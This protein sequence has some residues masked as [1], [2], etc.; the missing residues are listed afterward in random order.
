MRNKFNDLSIGQKLN[1]GFGILVLLLLL[2]VGLIFAAGRDATESINLT[3]DVRVPAALA[4][5]RRS[6]VC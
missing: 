3:I 2:I 6:Q 5:A 4:S 1:I